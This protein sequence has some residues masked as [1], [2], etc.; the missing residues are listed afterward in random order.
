MLVYLNGDWIPHQEARLP[1]TDRGFLFSDG[2]FDTARLH[3]GKYFRLDQH[4]Q[5]LQES[6]RMLRLHAPD[7]RQLMDIA[8]EIARRNDLTEASLRV[9]ITRGSGGSGLKTRGA[10]QPTLL[11]TISTMPDNW[12]EKAAAG[13]SLVTAR[14]LRPS[15]ESVPSQLKALGRVYAVLA[16]LEAESAGADDALLLTANR[17]IAEGPT[18]NFFWRKGRALRTGALEGGILEGVTRRIMIDLAREAGMQVEESLW[19]RSELDTADEAFATMTSQGVV[20]IRS[21]DDRELPARDCATL[22]QRR[23][24]ELVAAELRAS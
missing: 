12:R 19:P 1:I 5:R 3:Q 6:A 22:L 21:I 14:T 24:W 23:Y 15:P 11:A 8:H 17:E 2:V 20:P 9:T 18:W 13:W 10:D 7:S 4:L 16:T